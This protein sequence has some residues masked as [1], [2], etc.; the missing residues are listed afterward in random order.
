MEL[1]DLA[2][3]VEAIEQSLAMP[4]LP[5]SP[6]PEQEDEEMSDLEDAS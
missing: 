3:R 6:E 1:D 2:D 5:G 4:Q